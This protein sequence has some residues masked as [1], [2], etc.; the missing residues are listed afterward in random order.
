MGPKIVI[1]GGGIGGL[2]AALALARR[3]VAAEIYEQAPALE[4]V[5]AGVGLWG[6]ALRA[7]ETIGLADKVTQL[8][9]RVGRQGVKRPDGTWLTYF[10]TEA[11]ERRWGV[12]FAAVHRASCSSS[13]PPSST[14]RPSTSEPAVSPSGTPAGR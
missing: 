12:G 8:A 9:E 10:P 14:P 2:T 3:G 1:I 11:M 13:W 5:G 4:E 6:N 7:L